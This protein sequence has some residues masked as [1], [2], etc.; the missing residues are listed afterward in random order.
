MRF[1]RAD[2]SPNHIFF[3][4]LNLFYR[5]YTKVAEANE[6]Q[7]KSINTNNKL[8]AGVKLTYLQIKYPQSI[9][10]RFL[11]LV[12]YSK[13]ELMDLFRQEVCPARRC[14]IFF[15]EA[16]SKHPHERALSNSDNA[17][18]LLIFLIMPLMKRSVTEF[19]RVR[20]SRLKPCVLIKK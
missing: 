5:W 20:G 10:L 6:F 7:Q 11:T 12:L 13:T 2:I 15:G 9:F 19:S 17:C 16:V 4:Y 3:I 1:P 14:P 8:N 18:Q